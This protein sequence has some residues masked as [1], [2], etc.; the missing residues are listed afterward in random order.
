MRP[1]K[2]GQRFTTSV[3]QGVFNVK[4]FFGKSGVE[5]DTYEKAKYANPT[6]SILIRPVGSDGAVEADLC[7]L[8]E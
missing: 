8:A 7:E 3:I 6:G 4:C 2:K 5:Y 1:I